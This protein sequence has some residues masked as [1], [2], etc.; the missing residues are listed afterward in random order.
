MPSHGSA[1]I[2]IL[3]VMATGQPN[4]A[5]TLRAGL[6]AEGPGWRVS[7]LVCGAGPQDRPFEE[8]HEFVCIAAVTEGSFRYRSRHGDA[9]LAPGALLLGNAGQC[10]ECGHEHGIGDRCL[11]FHF[12]P[13]AFADI[14][15]AAPG[16]RRAEFRR[17][18][19]PPLPAMT[20]FLAESEAAGMRRDVRA[21]EELA[22][23]LAGGVARLLADAPPFE[24]SP[25]ARDE[26]RIGAVVRY[27]EARADDD[28]DI[29]TLA[30]VA[31][32]SPYHFLRTFR[33]VVGLTPHRFI[34]QTR[35]RRAAVR[36]RG[37]DAPITGIA[38]DA[39][40][41]DLSAFN[42]AFRATFGTTP[43]GY[44]AGRAASSL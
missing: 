21:I 18:H 23:R 13:E 37:S 36:L 17:H 30:D 43:T 25:T 15:A 27:I 31:R 12:T 7:D 20:R 9:L 39:G 28:L 14:A 4:N 8:R 44:R 2:A 32:M 34:L 24:A 41:N 3:T 19:L 40:F 26:K 38:F 16:V 11:A 35:L 1:E 5:P 29:G 6:I 10:F 33:R 42:R 22:F